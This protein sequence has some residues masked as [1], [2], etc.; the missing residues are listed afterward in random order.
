MFDNIISQVAESESPYVEVSIYS[1]KILA[2]LD[3]GASK[4][5]CKFKKI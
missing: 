5:I 2:L 4:Y 1:G 3:S